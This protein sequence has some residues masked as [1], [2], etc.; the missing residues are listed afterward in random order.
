[1]II[2]A[3]DPGSKESGYVA[4]DTEKREV[5]AK[6]I[7]PNGKLSEWLRTGSGLD[8]VAIE[9]PRGMGQTAGNEL[10]DTAIW[11]G[12]FYEAAHGHHRELIP[13]REVKLYLV[14]SASAKDKNVRDALIDMF[15]EPGSKKQPGKLY[16]VTSHML[17]ALAVAVTCEDRLRVKER[18]GR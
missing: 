3:I 1:M 12:I 14:G 10:L 7:W 15:G 2:G 8:V 4:Y 16:G 13:R 18:M 9:Q 17:S 11:T 6:V 5:C